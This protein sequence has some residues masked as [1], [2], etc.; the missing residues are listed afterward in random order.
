VSFRR[1]L[2]AVLLALA[3][4]T[5]LVGCSAGGGSADPSVGSSVV[6]PGNS[7]SKEAAGTGAEPAGTGVEVPVQAAPQVKY[8]LAHWS[9]YNT[10][11]FETLGEDDCVNFTSQGLLARGWAQTDEWFYGADGVYSSSAAWRSSTAFRDY[12][13]DH[14]ELA[15][16]LDDSQRDQ[17][18][19]GDIVQFDWDNSGDRDHTGTVTKVVKGSGGQV[20]VYF[21]GH[22]TDSDYRSVDDA[23]TVDHPGASVFYWHLS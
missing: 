9:E 4:P 6:E 22:T 16:A 19:P 15:T 8:V 20:T 1:A 23:I 3:I 5:V 17:V 10:A 11:E 18:V 21:A 13:R 2:P 12:L 14:P 7:A